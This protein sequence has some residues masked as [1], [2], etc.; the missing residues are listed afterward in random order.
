MTHLEALQ[1]LAAHRGERIVISTMG[2][3]ALWAGLSRSP[4]DF[5]YVPSAMG[6]ASALGLGLA[7]AQPERGVVVLAG[8]GSMLMNLGNLVTMASYPA[9]LFLLI[10]DNG[11]Y[12]VTGAQPTVASGRV[13][14]AGLARA[15][16]IVRV[17]A[18]DR[19]NAWTAGAQD[20]L[21]GAGPVVVWLKVAARAGQKAPVA[22]LPMAEQINR[23]QQAL[24]L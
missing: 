1:V 21:S 8:D 9:N 11:V 6:Q 22:P 14:F 18:F 16:G 5:A 24:Q 20:A 7:L 19:I 4:L 15:A 13:D 10:L 3:V 12:E 23:L 17:Y 2:S